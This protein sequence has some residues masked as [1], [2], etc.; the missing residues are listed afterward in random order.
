VTQCVREFNYTTIVVCNLNCE[1]DHMLICKVTFIAILGIMPI[2]LTETWLGNMVNIDHT[3]AVVDFTR[4]ASA[5]Y[6]FRKG[7]FSNVRIQHADCRI[8]VNSLH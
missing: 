8:S 6:R 7:E 5:K 1:R 2:K 3:S 4:F